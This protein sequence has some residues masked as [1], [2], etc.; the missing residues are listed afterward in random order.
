MIITC[1]KCSTSFNLDDSLV[2]EGG[3]KVRCSVCK[4]IFTAY[5]LPLEVDIEPEQSSDLDLK[6]GIEDEDTFEEPS[7]FEMEDS[8]LSFDTSEIEIDDG[9]EAEASDIEDEVDFFSDDD[10]LSMEN[11][12][13]EIEET[14]LEM[15]E[16]ALE[17]DDDD[18][19][20]LS[21]GS[22]LSMDDDTL[23]TGASDI[24]DE[25]DFFSGDDDMPMKNSGLELKKPGLDINDE[26]LELETRDVENDD[27]FS[28]EEDE[29]EIVDNDSL[30]SQDD[31]E[32]FD[33]IEFE[34]I[35]D[36]DADD[37][38]ITESVPIIP[39]EEK[40]E[41]SEEDTAFLDDPL[42]EDEEFELE[43]DIENNAGI[44]PPAEVE[45]DDHDESW[46][47]ALDEEK[48]STGPEPKDDF[49]EYDDVLEQETEPEEALSEEEV[50]NMEEAETLLKDPE[51]GMATAPVPP[52]RRNKKSPIGSIILILLLLAILVCGAYI[53]SI[54]T[55]YKIPYLS[56]VKIPFIEQLL[57]KGTPEVSEAKP[58]PNQE[59][60]NGRFVTNETAGTLFVI[61]GRVENPSNITYSHIEVRGAL[62]TKGKVEEKKKSTFCGNIITE[63]MLK[64]GN[65]SDINKLAMVKTGNHD[66]NVNIK[67]GT[68]V[69]FMIVFSDLPEKLQNFTVKVI[70]FETATAN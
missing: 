62:I 20:F 58:V 65:I 39:E 6:S 55:G 47:L 28:F 11:D 1:D 26:D 13:L 38:N 23:E 24:D 59:S 60:V 29:F 21:S 18:D 34:P 16:L 66:S 70:G 54:M 32:V 3:S 69:P 25:V 12:G 63:E 51:P 2:N 67:P 22:E 30:E 4:E 53:A 41:L 8:D 10:D 57:N 17:E 33:G 61:T 7:D 44:D 9:V 5:P 64:T 27:D 31:D 42:E 40:T 19:D 52:P 46:S 37:M 36:D 43:F 35:E 45:T 49:S 50:S 14:E 48:A 68:S 15:E 56:N